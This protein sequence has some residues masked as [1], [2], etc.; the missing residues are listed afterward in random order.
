MTV[1]AAATAPLSVAQEALFYQALLHPNRLSY[2][3]TIS[4]RHDGPFDVA[5]LRRAFDAF[6]ARHESWRTRFDVVGGT[7]VQ[8]IAPARPIAVPLVDLS[9][10]PAGRAERAA[11]RLVAEL[12]RVPYDLRRGPLV[13]PRLI[14]FPGGEHHRLY[15]A[16]HHIVFDG[17]SLY[18][19]VL[20]E[21]AELYAYEA[22]VPGAAP[23][24]APRAQYAD[25][26]RWE[27][28]WIDGPRAA[29]RIAHWRE[30]LTPPPAPVALPLDRPRPA[31]PRACGGVL[32][33]TVP[34]ATVARLRAVAQASGASLFQALGAAWSL[35]LSRYSGQSDLAFG[36]PADMRHRPEF[37]HV[38]GYCL[39]PLAIRVDTSGDPTFRELT[40]RVRNA[41]LDDFDRV[42]PFERIVRDLQPETPDGANP[43]YQTMLVLEPVTTSPDP[44]WSLH[45]MESEIGD[46]VGTARLDLE[47][48]LDERPAGHLAGR[49][50]YDRDLFDAATVQLLAERFL[51]VV[52]TASAEPDARTSAIALE[53]PE[54]AAAALAELTAIR[55]TPPPGAAEADAPA[56]ILAAE[57]GLSPADTI[58]V[59]PS[60]PLSERLA[61]ASGARTV[62]APDDVLAGG[63][64]LSR[65][66]K[67]EAV[68][69]LAASPATWRLL[70]DTGLRPTRSLRALVTGEPPSRALADA[71]LARVRVLWSA[72]EAALL[73]RIERD[74]PITLGR[75]LATADV[76]VLDVTGASAPIGI[77]GDLH[78][79]G[80]PTGLRARWLPD[81]RLAPVSSPG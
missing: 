9:A 63:A 19:V 34:A 5:A 45:V 58:L 46:A 10:L 17:V 18:R 44:A 32:G 54:R 55:V 13:R 48:Q 38:V 75:P 72:Y 31:E 71:L 22:G 76:A 8:I 66:I 36:T 39:T 65:L 56:A 57:L 74:R 21:L 60:W 20:R 78:L 30:R 53:P 4:L 3:E 33:V 41:L 28:E 35:V 14:R 47:L 24:S 69:V 40:V 49:L 42:F 26:A 2:N 81:G 15:L 29:R 51:H 50:I 1:A 73:T 16:L 12:S 25:V 68:S 52:Q 37:E 61:R 70:V 77:P 59:H 64:A 80:A 27:R 43:I 67:A 7:P 11:A 23:L 62:T 6:V 79:A